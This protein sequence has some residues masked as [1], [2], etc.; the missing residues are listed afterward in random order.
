M[1]HY[2][3]Y[4]SNMNPARVRTRGLVFDRVVGAHLADHALHFNKRSRKQRGA[5]HANIAESPGDVVEGVLYRLAGPDE[6]EKMD[7]F[8]G[9]PV[10]YRRDVVRV[11]LARDGDIVSAWTYFGNEAVLS[12]GLLPPSWY[13][14]HLLAGREYLTEAYVRRLQSTRCLPH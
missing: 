13:M 3:A 2:F 11:C 1:H 14:E 12:D 8:E 4:G 7:P 10:Q 6:I 5:G 9:A